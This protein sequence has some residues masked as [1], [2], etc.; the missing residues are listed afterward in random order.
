LKKIDKQPYAK[1][2]FVL[3]AF[4][5]FCNGILLE[6]EIHHWTLPLNASTMDHVLFG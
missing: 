4:K 5:G 6:D 2:I 3:L 1:Q